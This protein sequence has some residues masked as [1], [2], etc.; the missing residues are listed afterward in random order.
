MNGD[1]E[2][3]EALRPAAAGAPRRPT[4]RFMLASPWHL[5]ALGAGS[6]LPR[7]APG[8][9]GTLLAWL[10]FLRL[11]QSLSTTYWWL[12]VAAML[13]VGALAAQRTGER[14]GVADSGHIVIDEIVA[15]WIV[16]LLLPGD[17][18]HGGTMLVAAFVLFRFFDI[19]KPPPI[20]ALDERFA[21]GAGVMAD[22]L[23][24]AFYTLLVL[25]VGVRLWG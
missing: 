7:I 24:A 16:L 15:F 21:N 20:R 18:A 17:A 8:T 22:D 13:V 25:A 4:L 6:G 5:I 10:L 23:V 3:V 9:W 11:D 19:V 2:H 12:L 1:H 14:L